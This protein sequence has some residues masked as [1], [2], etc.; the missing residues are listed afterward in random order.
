M[1]YRKVFFYNLYNLSSPIRRKRRLKKIT[2]FVMHSWQIYRFDGD[3]LSLEQVGH[4]FVSEKW[5]T[6]Q[7]I[8]L[9]WSNV[10]FNH[11]FYARQGSWLDARW[12]NAFKAQLLHK[13]LA[14]YSKKFYFQK[15]DFI[16]TIK[17]HKNRVIFLFKTYFSACLDHEFP[18]CF[19]AP[20]TSDMCVEINWSL[21]STSGCRGNI[22][23]ILFA[24]YVV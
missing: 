3:K 1:Q 16:A 18:E 7:Q 5:P 24:S 23:F 10:L 14:I 19:C 13:K 6:P 20:L 22:I 9:I 12:N 11:W 2:Q 15:R 21:T 4:C 8:A 17:T